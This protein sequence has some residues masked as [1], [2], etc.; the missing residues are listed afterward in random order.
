LIDLKPVTEAEWEV[1]NL[2]PCLEGTREAILKDIRD[3]LEGLDN[4]PIY[5]LTGSAGTGKSCISYTVCQK[6]SKEGILGATFF[7]SRDQDTRSKV[8]L[9]FRTLAYRLAV[10]FPSL[11]LHILE[12]LNTDPALLGPLPERHF[13]DLVVRSI[14]HISAS[15]SQPILIVIDALD[16]S[17][18]KD[19]GSVVGQFISL[20]VEELGDRTTRLKVFVTS[21]PDDLAPVF[22]RRNVKMERLASLVRQYD[23]ETSIPRSDLNLYV[24]HKMAILAEKYQSPGGQLWPSSEDIRYVLRIAG[25][26]FI[27]AATV[28]RMLELADKDDMPNPRRTLKGLQ[29]ALPDIQAAQAVGTASHELDHLYREVLKVAAERHKDGDAGRN[30]RRLLAF[31]VLSFHPLPARDIGVLLGFV[32]DPLLPVLHPVLGTPS[33][34]KPLRALHTSFHDFITDPKRCTETDI[35][36]ISP[37]QSHLDLA[38]ACLLQLKHL[39]CDLLGLGATGHQN[40]DLADAIQA[41]ITGSQAYAVRYWETHLSRCTANEIMRDSRLLNSLNAFIKTSVLQYIEALSYLNFLAEGRASMEKTIKIS[42][43]SDV[44]RLERSL[45]IP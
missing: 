23:V 7:F 42:P 22:S 18:W 45:L 9:A 5:W 2:D 10:I 8:D 14:R 16:E 17:Q 12:A 4:P 32:T 43:V 30:I 6:Y 25:S 38:V 40:V 29:A 21:R 36:P 3:W 34:K 39:N 19:D 24:S 35:Q 41:K 1:V 27:S 20:L 26:L 31:V 11:R 13:R 44:V 33:S 28:L 37:S 15:L